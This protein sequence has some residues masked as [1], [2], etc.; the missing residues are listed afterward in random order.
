MI[1][2]SFSNGYAIFF[3]FKTKSSYLL[4]LFRFIFETESLT[5]AGL[6]LTYK[7]LVLASPS[8]EIDS[9]LFLFCLLLDCVDSLIVFF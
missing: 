7:L 6:K 8:A 9:E 1:A 5:Q 2:L 3:S 4:N